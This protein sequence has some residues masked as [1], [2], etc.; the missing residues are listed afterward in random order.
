MRAGAAKLAESVIDTIENKTSDLK[1]LYKDSDKPEEK[2]L[3]IAKEIYRVGSLSFSPSAS[4]KLKEI[5]ELGFD[6][7]PVCMAKTQVSAQ[8]LQKNVHQKIMICKFEK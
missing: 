4:K 7:F 6:H 2:I 8:T 1:F 5:S 3:K